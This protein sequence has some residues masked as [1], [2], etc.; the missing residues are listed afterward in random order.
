MIRVGVR[1]RLIFSKK[2][3]PSHAMAP[4]ELSKRSERLRLMYIG[5]DSQTT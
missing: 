4:E 2:W 3:A 1:S 5:G